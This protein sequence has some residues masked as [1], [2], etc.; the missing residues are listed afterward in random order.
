[1]IHVYPLNDLREHDTGETTMCWCQPR[2]EF[3]DPETGEP[4]A[5]AL[6]I[7]SSADGR[8]LVEQAEGIINKAGSDKSCQ[9]RRSST[10]PQ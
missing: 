9:S 6:V 4:Y 5:E 1:M 2:V 7:H 10:P 3:K 8:E